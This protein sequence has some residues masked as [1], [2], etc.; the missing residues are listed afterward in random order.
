L[1]H[2][3]TS[4]TRRTPLSSGFGVTTF[5][6]DEA[7]EI[8]ISNA[9]DGTIWLIN[10]TQAPRVLPSGVT[11]AASFQDGIVPGSLVTAFAYGVLDSPGAVVANTVP[12]PTSL[13]SISV[14][15]NGAAAPVYSLGNAGGSELV[16]FQAPFELAGQST[17]SIA[18]TRKRN[19]RSP[20]DV[21]V[22]DT[23]PDVCTSDGVQAMVVHA[24]D[25]S[26]VTQAKPLRRGEDA[27]LYASGLGP[28][29]NQPKTGAGAPSS[30]VAVI[31]NSQ[32]VTLGSVPATNV[33]A[34]LAPGFVGV[35]QVNFHVPDTTP[36][37]S[38][39]LTLSMGTPLRQRSRQQFNKTPSFIP[40][41]KRTLPDEQE[42]CRGRLAG[43]ASAGSR[44]CQPPDNAPRLP[45]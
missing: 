4:W 26:L 24:V 36:T 16:S 14:I 19:P 8:Y 29:S 15:V 35:Y 38:L 21:P 22:M 43:L 45:T 40:A 41:L 2:E 23:Q 11:N 12:L 32:A 1:Q 18:I 44:P 39:D 37:G 34:A 5:G 25:Y 31:T 6:V 27:F 17:A 13:N 3:S 7:G 20:I 30:P 10:G 9:D 28:V 42:R 33:V